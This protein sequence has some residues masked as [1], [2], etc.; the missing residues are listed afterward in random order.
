MNSDEGILS[1]LKHP[2]YTG[3]NRCLPCTGVNILI[4]AGLGVILAYISPFVGGVAVAVSL[5]VIYIRGYLVPGTPTLTRRYLPDPVLRIFGKELDPYGVLGS[6]NS[7]EIDVETLLVELG[8]VESCRS[9][10]D[11]CLDEEFSSAWYH[12]IGTVSDDVRIGHSQLAEMLQIDL[13]SLT[14]G[15]AGPTSTYVAEVEDSPTVA[16][17][18]SEIAFIA[19]MA[20]SAEIDRRNEAW[21]DLTLAEQDRVLK[22]LRIFLD[23]CP[24]CEA[25]FDLNHDRRNSCCVSKNVVRIE[26]ESCDTV[27][28]EAADPSRGSVQIS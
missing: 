7:G 22:S 14:F 12:R 3:E 20:A 13:A 25:P 27:I 6:S 10:D 18:E 11:L 21:T 5:L 15:T 2:E 17:W 24:N 8:V 9:T 23:R 28:L 4:A 19:D 26:C 1:I 16:T